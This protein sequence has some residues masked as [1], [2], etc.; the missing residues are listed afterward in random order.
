MVYQTDRKETLQVGL[1]NPDDFAQV[2]GVASIHNQS[3]CASAGNRRRWKQFHHIIS[4]HTLAS[5]KNIKATWVVAKTALLADALATC[6]F[7]VPAK[8]LL[9]K[10]TFSYATVYEDNTREVSKAFP[11]EIFSQTSKSI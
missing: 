5:P 10:F 3:I 6:L 9:A 4:P 8:T 2:I 7:F 11:A 1:E